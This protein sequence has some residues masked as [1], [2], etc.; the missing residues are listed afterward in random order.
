MNLFPVLH[1]NIIDL[2][3]LVY[4]SPSIVTMTAANDFTLNLLGTDNQIPFINGTN[5]GFEYSADLTFDGI[6]LN[7]GTTINSVY[8]LAGTQII[9]QPVSTRNI[10]IGDGGTNLAHSAAFEG[11]NNTFLGSSCGAVATTA[12]NN[13]GAGYR[14]LVALTTGYENW[15]GG[16]FTFES[17][18]GGFRNTSAGYYSSH[19]I[20]GGLYNSVFGFAAL[21]NAAG[22]RAGN[23]AVGARALGEG[24]AI[25][26][27]LGLGY[28]AGRYETGDYKVFID[29][30]DRTTE[31]AGR[32]GSLI[33]GVC[34]ATPA[35]QTLALNAAVT[36]PY[37]LG[38]TGLSTLTGGMDAG[39][40]TT[41]L[42]VEADGDTFWTG[43]GTGL[44]YGSFYGN[45]IAFSSGALA[46][47]QYVI[48]ADTDCVTGEVN[49][50][51]YTDAGTTLTISKAGRYKI[52]WA[53][54][55]EATSANVHVLGGI[56]I[57]STTVL[58]AAGRNHVE[59]TIAN[60]QL[61]MSG[62]AIIDCPNG[63]EV[64]GVGVGSDVDNITVVVD[65]VNL[66]IVMIGGT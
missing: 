64:I 5:N 62:T 59:T 31:A 11:W 23:T 43:D 39:G 60:R 34:N 17:L 55:C 49:E 42:S 54:S 32:T 27:C 20:I 56:M 51:T 16:A 30:I 46:A 33:Y 15:G 65:H 22:T 66:S 4:A 37:T 29:T 44:P 53:V 3:G 24:T 21:G 36:I 57:D 50:V 8:K 35:N 18:V 26:Y 10:V 13:F 61:P 2:S 47:P 40:A 25:D 12:Y 1:P 63:T 52:D 19:A 6:S 41:K 45:E 58:Q 38:V 14:C 9:A 48:I 7:V 28:Y